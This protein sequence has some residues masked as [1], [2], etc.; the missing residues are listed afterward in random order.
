MNTSIKH[1]PLLSSKHKHHYI[2]E[3]QVLRMIL[4][5]WLMNDTPQ[6]TVKC[7]ASFIKSMYVCFPLFLCYC[8]IRILTADFLFLS[9]SHCTLHAMLLLA[10][11]F[12]VNYII[13]F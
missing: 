3:N 1:E 12:P 9:F 11:A 10:L 5:L 13:Y 4:F 8:M 7:N 6:H 2:V